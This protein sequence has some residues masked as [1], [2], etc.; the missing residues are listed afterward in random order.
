MK[1]E[2]DSKQCQAT[3]NPGKW[4]YIARCKK[5]RTGKGHYCEEH[6]VDLR[7]EIRDAQA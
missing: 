5:K 6:T 3:W 1:W 2:D 7:K 4:P